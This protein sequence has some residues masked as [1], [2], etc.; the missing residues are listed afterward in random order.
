VSRIAVTVDLRS[1]LGP[2]RDQGSRPTCLAFAASDAH[3]GLRPGWAP[4]SCE[5]AFHHAQR[6]AARLPSQGALLSATLETL[7]EDGQPEEAG[8]PYLAKLPADTASWVPPP[9]VGEVFAR[10]G[11]TTSATVSAAVKELDEGHPLILLLQLSASFFRPG[12]DGVVDP[13]PGEVPEQ[14]RRHAVIAVG[15]GEVDGQAAILVRNSWGGR[16]A[17]GGYAW[18]TEAFVG[19]RLF[20]AAKLTEEVDVL[21]S[22]AAA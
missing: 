15:H 17:A 13:A 21:G 5:F 12:P 6:R 10:D 8:W 14:E 18:L 16:W 19:P 11:E 4:L 20:A 7:R 3:A 22:S 1:M 2:V 9:T